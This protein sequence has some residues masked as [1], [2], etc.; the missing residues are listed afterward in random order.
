MENFPKVSERRVAFAPENVP[1]H[2]GKEQ[3]TGGSYFLKLCLRR[4]L[5]TYML[6]L[7]VKYDDDDVQ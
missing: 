5:L 7:K 6:G 1:V 2:I 4:L 3:L